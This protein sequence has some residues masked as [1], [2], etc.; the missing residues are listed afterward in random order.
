MLNQAVRAVR[1]GVFVSCLGLASGGARRGVPPA[2][3]GTGHIP[4]YNLS[5]GFY[6]Q[7]RLMV[8]G[9]VSLASVAF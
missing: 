2:R 5:I 8:V 6:E 3:R 1:P 4:D 7:S 9:H